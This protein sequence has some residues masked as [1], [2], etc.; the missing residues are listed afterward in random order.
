MILF[1][2]HLYERM[3]ELGCLRRKSRV[4]RFPK[5]PPPYLRDFIRG[6][7]DGDGSV[8]RVHYIMTKNNKPTKE[9][10]SNFTS[11]SK[12]FLEELMKVLAKELGFKR[13]SLGSYNDGGSLKLGYG[14]KDTRSLLLYMYYPGCS[15]ALE[16]KRA[17]LTE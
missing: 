2:K 11:G 17:F 12:E 15:L 13:K 9:L 14:T 4:V 10:R 16:R 3:Q 5:V 7:F 8:F 1:S 6:Y